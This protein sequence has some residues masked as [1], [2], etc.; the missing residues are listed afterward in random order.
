MR[1]HWQ[2]DTWRLSSWEYK[3]GLDQERRLQ[4]L[5]VGRP[6]GKLFHPGWQPSGPT[7][8]K[9][10]TAVRSMRRGCDPPSST[11]RPCAPFIWITDLTSSTGA[12]GPACLQ[13]RSL[14]WRRLCQDHMA[15]T[16]RSHNA[17]YPSLSPNPHHITLLK[18]CQGPH[19]PP[20]P[21]LA[22]HTNTPI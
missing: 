11:C 10:Y 20:G 18:S 5:C 14:P 8:L 2:T 12:P 22:N 21:W 16:L 15:H 9:G 1:V 13:V 7:A 3:G 6:E 19:S 4:Q 17:T